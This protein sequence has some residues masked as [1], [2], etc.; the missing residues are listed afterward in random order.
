MCA[1]IW[2]RLLMKLSSLLCILVSILLLPACESGD[3]ASAMGDA[4][5][6]T[7][8]T[9]GE[10]LKIV[11]TI[12]PLALL[13]EALLN[14]A[15]NV[16]VYTLLPGSA[17]PHNF[18]LRVSDRKALTE[19]DLV[20]WVGSALERF[21][22]K[23]MAARTAA[24]QVVML[25]LPHMAF[26]EPVGDLHGHSHHDETET[27]D[28]HVWL[29]P[30]N[31]QIMAA[32]IAARLKALRPRQ[33]AVIQQN[34][35]NLDADLTAFS[36]KTSARFKA[37]KDEPFAVHHNALGHFV[38]SFGLNQVVAVNNSPEERLSAHQLELLQ[39]RV[40]PA[41]CLLVE[42]GSPAQRLAQTLKLP[43][44]EVDP[45]ATSPQITSYLQLL[46]ALRGSLE[47]CFA[48]Q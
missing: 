48:A 16:E 32:A 44:V 21:L 43:M 22:V 38:Q 20:L 5:A 15:D 36:A 40:A 39:Q 33:A 14:G 17:D 10:T 1:R 11:V 12:R 6:L 42:T 41:R 4:A 9:E 2:P 24:E 8:T 46:E 7:G 35:E 19:A 13:A 37:V 30:E 47:H 23:P 27:R 34:L 31:A 28:P 26:P 18:A 3:R 25:S 29:G 45:L